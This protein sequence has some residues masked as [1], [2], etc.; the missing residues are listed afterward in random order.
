MTGLQIAANVLFNATSA[1]TG[2]PVTYSQGSSSVVVTATPGKSRMVTDTEG[3]ARIEVESN[4]WICFAASLIINSV[5]I[6]PL[7]GDRVTY[8][9]S[10]TGIT[11]VYELM[12]PPYSPSDSAGVLR[13]LHS[14]IISIA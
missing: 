8:V 5:T 12:T 10:L 14:K 6:T 9:N 2:V 4:D 1:F 13:R 3:G 7:E 11:T